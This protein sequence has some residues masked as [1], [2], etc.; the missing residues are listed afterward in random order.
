[1]HMVCALVHRTTA[2]L[3]LLLL[4]A[5]VPALWACW[6]I[7]GEATVAEP[8]IAPLVAGDVNFELD[9]MPILTAA[10]CNAGACHGKARGQNGFQLSLLGFDPDFD[11]AAIAKE[12][13]GRRIFPASPDNSLLLRKPTLAMP[14]GGGQRLKPDSPE[15]RPCCA[16]GSPRACPAS[17]AAVRPCHRITVEPSEHVLAAGA[18]EQLRVLAH[19][20]DGSIRDVTRWLTSSR[21]KPA[22]VAVERQTAWSKPVRCRAKRR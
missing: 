20:S 14:H 1:M 17:G 21:T 18:S 9:V 6:S 11:F 4:I 8:A 3:A 12:A 16:A 5:L 22:V 10:G 13:H 19:Y 15:Y 7:A 2:R